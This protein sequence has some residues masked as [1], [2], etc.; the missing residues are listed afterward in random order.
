MVFSSLF[1]L[2]FISVHSISASINIRFPSVDRKYPSGSPFY[3]PCYYFSF[4]QSIAN[5]LKQSATQ[6]I[7]PLFH[8][9]LFLLQSIISLT[10]F[11]PIPSISFCQVLICTLTIA[12]SRLFSLPSIYPIR[13]GVLLHYESYF[14][15]MSPGYVS[16]RIK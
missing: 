12:R 8:Y 13:T 3:Y 14:F 7:L 4:D 1:T 9:I 15:I 10:D 16:I 11:F 5:L 6:C 2:F